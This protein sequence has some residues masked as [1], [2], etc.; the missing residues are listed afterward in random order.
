MKQGPQLS[1]LNLPHHNRNGMASISMEPG[2]ITQA[3]HSGCSFLVKTTTKKE[4]NNNTGS[5]G[6][7]TSLR[8]GGF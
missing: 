6:T 5:P 1:C 2:S 8:M 4:K 3:V 7:Y